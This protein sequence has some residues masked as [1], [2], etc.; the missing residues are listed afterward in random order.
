ML[1]FSSYQYLN[2]RLSALL[3]ILNFLHKFYTK[4]DKNLDISM[5]LWV[6]STTTT[7]IAK[8]RIAKRR[9]S[10]P[11]TRNALFVYSSSKR[12]AANI[13]AMTNCCPHSHSSFSA[14]WNDAYR[15]NSCPFI[16]VHSIKITLS[17][18][19]RM[20]HLVIDKVLFFIPMM[21]SDPPTAFLRFVYKLI[22]L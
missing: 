13:N 7:D 2:M 10:V 19:V 12:R 11:Y 22:K 16:E 3:T 5:V 4:A 15:S 8:N 6:Y 17:K 20:K 9:K 14:P 21:C 1:E 18:S